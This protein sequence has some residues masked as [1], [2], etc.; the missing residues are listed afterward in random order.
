[1]KRRG[2]TMIS[3]VMRKVT[4]GLVM[5]ILG[6]M[7]VSLVVVP[8]LPISNPAMDGRQWVVREMAKHFPS[9]L[10]A[11]LGL[12]VEIRLALILVM[13][14]PTCLVV[15]VD[16]WEVT[17]MVD[18]LILLDPA[19]ARTSS[20]HTNPVT[21]KEVTLQSFNKEIAEQGISWILL[22]Y[23]QQAKGQFVLE[24]VLEDV[25]RS[26]DGAVRVS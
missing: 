22:F 18:L 23:T 1:M 7:R 6:T 16:Q 19:G 9:H 8:R 21:I 20:Q 2:T 26:L 12:T 4:Q 14:F 5:D 11:T 25:A 10:V 15:V 17:S 24:S 13:F 3:T